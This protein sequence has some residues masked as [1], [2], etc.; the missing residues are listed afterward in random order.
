MDEFDEY[1]LFESDSCVR[2]EDSF[3]SKC[4]AMS[5]SEEMLMKEK[6]MQALD[7][8]VNVLSKESRE[9]LL[10]KL[11]V[12]PVTTPRKLPYHSIKNSDVQKH[13]RHT[14]MLA[15]YLISKGD[16]YGIMID[17]C[18]DIQVAR[19]MSID[20]P[21]LAVNV[22]KRRRQANPTV[23]EDLASRLLAN[24]AVGYK[25]HCKKRS[26][27]KRILSV[28]AS[29]ITYSEGRR[30]FACGPVQF[31]EAKKHY[32]T[33]GPFAEAKAS[34]CPDKNIIESFIKKKNDSDEKAVW[35]EFCIKHSDVADRIGRE[36]F[37]KKLKMSPFGS[38]A[39]SVDDVFADSHEDTKFYD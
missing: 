32:T 2:A 12:T 26:E 23:K 33:F 7:E 18:E 16:P 4:F 15:A 9:Y 21:Y 8:L 34:A 20:D 14:L 5:H 24:L 13:L 6:E 17:T 38:S 39:D 19:S 27:K 28:V 37:I 11:Q 3:G 22:R 35:K 31:S 25:Q 36:A 10:Y 30:L 29:E 1:S